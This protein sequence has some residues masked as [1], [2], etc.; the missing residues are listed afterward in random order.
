MINPTAAD[1]K[2][3]TGKANQNGTPTPRNEDRSGIPAYPDEGRVTEGYLA[4]ESGQEIQADSPDDRE[5][6]K[7]GYVQPVGIDEPEVREQYENREK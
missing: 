4:R 7:I 1:I 2:P 3:A 5:P 6:G